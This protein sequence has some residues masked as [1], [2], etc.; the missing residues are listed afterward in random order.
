M[1]SG[2]LLRKCILGNM[3]LRFNLSRIMLRKGFLAS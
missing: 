1:R 3:Y 2:I